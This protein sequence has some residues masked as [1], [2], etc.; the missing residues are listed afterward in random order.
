MHV[1]QEIQTRQLI[2]GL[3]RWNNHLAGIVATNLGE[4]SVRYRRPL[5]QH[6]GPPAHTLWKKRSKQKVQKDVFLFFFCARLWHLDRNTGTV[7]DGAVWSLLN[8]NQPVL[9]YLASRWTLINGPRKACC[10]GTTLNS[11]LTAWNARRA[12]C[13]YVEGGNPAFWVSLLFFLWSGVLCLH[14]IITV[15][16]AQWDSRHGFVDVAASLPPSFYPPCLPPL[17]NPQKRLLGL[18]LPSSIGFLQM[19]P[20]GLFLHLRGELNWNG[21]WCDRLIARA[22]TSGWGKRGRSDRVARRYHHQCHNG[23]L[24]ATSSRVFFLYL[25]FVHKKILC[26]DAK[27]RFVLFFYL[28]SPAYYLLVLR[29]IDNKT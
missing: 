27:L 22:D 15:L 12:G 11:T 10:L 18:Q 4:V 17:E 21:K 5:W 7:I 1:W 3:R 14:P 24:A 25:W 6:K 23:V 28:C 2:G 9:T 8:G 19:V 26:M 29:R 13:G 16:S 20:F